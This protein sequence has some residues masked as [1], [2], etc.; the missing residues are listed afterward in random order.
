M[1]KARSIG[2]PE[3]GEVYL[4]A[5]DPAVGAEMQKT[6]P[7]VVLQNDVA[8]RASPVTIVAAVTSNVARATYATSVAVG[9]RDGGLSV[10]SV[11]LLNQV[12]TVD[13]TRLKQRLGALSE[14]A[15]RRI[16]LALKISLG[17]IRL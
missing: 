16:D 3:R 17:L 13:K 2:H 7:A 4:V 14:E 9:A 10:D 12:R 15:M 6:R 5:F 11:V 1:A 8:N